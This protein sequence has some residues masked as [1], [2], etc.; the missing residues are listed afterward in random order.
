MNINKKPS[1]KEKLFYLNACLLP[2]VPSKEHPPKARLSGHSWY[3][4][5][6]GVSFVS[7]VLFAIIGVL[8]T[9]KKYLMG[10]IT[11]ID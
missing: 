3:I 9:G 11:E 2:K 8:L 7:H 4:E 5:C 6:T 10:S 1:N